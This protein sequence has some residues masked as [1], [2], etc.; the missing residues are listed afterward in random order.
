MSRRLLQ[1]ALLLLSA[2]PCSAIRAADPNE[3]IREDDYHG[4]LRVAC[5]GDSITQGVGAESGQSYPDQLGKLL[6]DALWEVSQLRRLWK[7]TVGNKG[8]KPY[9]EQKVM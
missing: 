4:T 2:I 1:T 6:G 8:D 5:V 3:P 9:Q 7:A